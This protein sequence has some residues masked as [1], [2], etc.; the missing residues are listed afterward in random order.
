V[1]KAGLWGHYVITRQDIPET[2]QIE[3]VIGLIEEI[4]GLEGTTEPQEKL[5]EWLLEQNLNS[6]EWL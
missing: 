3:D 2:I 5:R 6:L 1:I 4:K